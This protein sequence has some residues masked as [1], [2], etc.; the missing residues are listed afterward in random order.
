MSS[1]Q[2]KDMLISSIEERL[3][4]A[5]PISYIE[6]MIY[7]TREKSGILQIALVMPKASVSFPLGGGNSSNRFGHAKGLINA[8]MSSNGFSEADAFRAS[9]Q[10]PLDI[11]A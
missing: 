1:S 8:S 11:W 7:H 10:A 3:C 2:E 6:S 5:T 4:T 9:Q